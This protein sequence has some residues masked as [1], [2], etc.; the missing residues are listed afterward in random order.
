MRRAATVGNTKFHH[1][2][3]R[4]RATKAADHLDA[5]RIRWPSFQGGKSIGLCFLY[6][7]EG[8]DRDG[9]AWKGPE[10]RAGKEAR[11]PTWRP[12]RARRAVFVRRGR[13]FVWAT[14]R[15]SRPTGPRPSPSTSVPAVAA[16]RASSPSAHARAGTR[17]LGWR[18]WS[19]GP[20]CVRATA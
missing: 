19:R 10:G 7:P 20:A 2:V 15:V 4:I 9:G 8:P 16:G 11:T 12:P 6:F 3:C 14:P 17:P 1:P 13:A 18:T 5:L